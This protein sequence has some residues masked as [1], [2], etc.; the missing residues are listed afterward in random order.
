MSKATAGFDPRR[1]RELVSIHPREA[2]WDLL[3]CQDNI[4][5]MNESGEYGVEFD[6]EKA[7]RA[8]MID[9]LCEELGE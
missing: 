4:T 6:Q 5:H 9:V 2:I 1:Y 8:A 3:R 7:R